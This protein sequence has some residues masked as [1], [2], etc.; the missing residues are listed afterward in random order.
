MLGIWIG[1]IVAFILRLRGHNATS[2]P[3]KLALRVSPNLIKKL[4][5]QL[6]RCI[7]VTGTNGKTTSTSFLS[8][9]MS[10]DETIITNA[11][12]A[13]LAQGIATALLLGSTAF[14]RIRAKTAVLE[15]DEATFPLIAGSLPIE[16]TIVTNVFRDQLD[17]YGELDTTLQKI[18]EGIRQTNCNLLLN[19]DDPL[20]RHIGLHTSNKV[21]YFGMS[22]NNSVLQNRSQMRDG[23][24]CLECGSE[25][26]YEQFIYGQLGYYHCPN[27]D[28]VRP[29][30]DFLGSYADGCL[31]IHGNSDNVTF[32]LPTR[33]LF[34][35]YNAL[36][37][38]CAARIV[39][40]PDESIHKGIDQ[41][42]APTGRMQMFQTSPPTILNLIKNPTG[43]DSVL[44]AI[45]IDPSPKIICIAINDLAADGRDVSWLWDADF[46]LIAESQNIESCITSGFRAEDM[47]LRLKY[48]GYPLS[49]IDVNPDIESAIDKA[50]EIGILHGNI[51]VYV[52]TTYT[53]LHTTADY[54][55]GKVAYDVKTIEN[56]ASVS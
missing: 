50:L 34:N 13:N 40:I 16:V 49:R 30:P 23:A 35:V 7:V 55:H 51:P 14:G 41:F 18:M 26:K 29:N 5:G 25:L 10:Q 11:Q 46:E 45:C 2:L 9:M 52:M 17:R 44:Q 22:P 8:G 20:A 43:C 27:C 3:G 53:M 42:H 48:A 39:G 28:F 21:Y 36:S 47:A 32:T 19:G 1:K 4:G 38:I 56:R 12:G 24:F 31:T 37:A 54:L 33:G 6:E 15:I